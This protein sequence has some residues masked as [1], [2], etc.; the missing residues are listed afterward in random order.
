M[1]NELFDVIAVEIAT[2]KKRIIAENKTEEDAE[3]IVMM[4]VM[5][6]GVEE[7]FFKAVPITSRAADTCALCGK[8]LIMGVCETG[9]GYILPPRT[10]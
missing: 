5:R 10:T 7:E 9:C 2:G 8:P 4:A 6:R 3:A 1:E